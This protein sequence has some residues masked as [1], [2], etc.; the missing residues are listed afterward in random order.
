MEMLFLQALELQN[1]LLGA[2]RLA[3]WNIVGTDFYQFHLLFE[4]I[5][6]TVEGKVDILAEQARGTRVEIKASIFNSV[7]ELTWATGPDL[8][9][10]LQKLNI[11]FR[12]GLERLREEAE[13]AKNYGVVNIVED[14]LS[15]C[16]TI[17]YLLGSILE[18]L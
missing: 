11:E 15:D 12:E 18:E 8:C 10:K 3:H 4:R 14:I 7:P 2:A 13:S 16:N 5:Y 1:N 9:E 17:E 6:E